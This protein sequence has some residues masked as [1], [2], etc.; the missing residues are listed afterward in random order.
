[1]N[2]V[3]IE[4]TC[5][6]YFFAKHNDHIS[7]ILQTLEQPKIHHYWRLRVCKRKRCQR[8]G[9]FVYEYGKGC[10]AKSGCVLFPPIDKPMIDCHRSFALIMGRHGFLK[11]TFLV[12][13]IEQQIAICNEQVCEL[14]PSSSQVSRNQGSLSR[15]DGA[16]CFFLMAVY[17]G[18][19]RWDALPH[20]GMKQ[21]LPN[22]LLL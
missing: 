19:L 4:L 3:W 20:V 13:A 9:S 21:T 18:D 17:P 12:C 14:L 8:E 7:T 6:T 5:I 22:K 15:V 1:M 2:I 10:Q 11:P 16:D